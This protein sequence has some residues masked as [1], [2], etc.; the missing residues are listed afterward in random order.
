MKKC[1]VAVFACLLLLG[2]L[3]VVGVTPASAAPKLA[4]CHTEFTIDDQGGTFPGPFTSVSTGRN[5]CTYIGVS[6]QVVV[7]TAFID[8][9]P[10]PPFVFPCVTDDGRSGV[11]G[12]VSQLNTVTTPNGKSQIVLATGPTSTCLAPPP[13]GVQ[14]TSGVTSW[15]VVSGTGKWADACDPTVAHE[16][17]ID[18]SA[19]PPSGVTKSQVIS[20]DC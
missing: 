10:G 7:S 9:A 5:N 12:T 1:H 19:D 13:T 8:V 20:Q 11:T 16:G 6:D 4:H 2:G 15:T 17:T 18:W 3:L 14:I